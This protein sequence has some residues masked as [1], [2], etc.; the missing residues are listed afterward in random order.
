MVRFFSKLY[1][2]R[3]GGRQQEP[4]ALPHGHGHRGARGTVAPVTAV[5]HDGMGLVSL[6]K[7]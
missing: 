4:T 3:R 1:I 5:G 6:K 7:L 2:M